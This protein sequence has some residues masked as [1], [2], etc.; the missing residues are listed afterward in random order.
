M[1]AV[2][3]CGSASLLHASEGQ[4]DDHAKPG[5]PALWEESSHE[6]E[7]DRTM[8]K[9]VECGTEM[10]ACEA[11]QF[12]E[13]RD[14]RKKHR[15]RIRTVTSRGSEELGRRSRSSQS[16]GGCSWMPEDDDEDEIE[17]Q[18]ET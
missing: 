6:R 16:L 12:E 17:A 1:P 18:Q 14:C 5:V 11:S 7:G 13:C 8:S 10:D 2:W 3:V 9:C 4:R 15:H